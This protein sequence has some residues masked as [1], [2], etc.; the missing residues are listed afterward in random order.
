MKVSI[1]EFAAMPIVG[2]TIASILT[3]LG[4]NDDDLP[5][6]MP[7]PPTFATEEEAAA[8]AMA[9]MPDVARKI[10]ELEGGA[11]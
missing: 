5:H 6:I 2:P 9:N 7:V 8:W 3:A 11:P 1:A 4:I 10:L